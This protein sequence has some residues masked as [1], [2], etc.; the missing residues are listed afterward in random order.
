[1]NEQLIKIKNT[2]QE[3]DIENSI[4][5]LIKLAQ[6]YSSRFQNDVI[7]Q[8]ANFQQVKT[9][10]RRG[11]SSA[12]DIKREKKRIMFTLLE[13]IDVIDEEEIIEENTNDTDTSRDSDKVIK[14]LFLAAN[15]L[16]TPFL[17]L[18]EEIR[19]IDLVLRKSEFRDKF[20]LIQHWAVRVKDIQ[21]LLLRHQPDIVH[22]SGHGSK[23]SEII[24]Q[25]DNGA[26]HAVN[27]RALS[28]LFSILKDN[29]RCVVLNACYTKEQAEAIAKN[30]DCVI[31]MSKAIGD[32]A[33]ISFAA[34]FYQG[35]GYGRDVQTAFD[36]GCVQIDLENLNEQDTPQL[37][38]VKDE[39]SEG[40]EDYCLNKAMD[41][42]KGSPL[43]DRG[44]ALE[45]LEEQLEG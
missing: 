40:L 32:D 20:D 22:F 30:I 18:D 27:S 19:E 2:I 43:L 24:L 16:D 7:L 10:E 42:A 34:A 5:Q 12:E 14:I 35:L 15:P 37:I 23:A 31:G 28:Q 11:I 39:L 41:E 29:I 36:L 33:A 44:A 25:N 3:G 6:K 21:E 45:F 4:S 9:D 8:S 1:M 13:L 38:A 17:K 26:K